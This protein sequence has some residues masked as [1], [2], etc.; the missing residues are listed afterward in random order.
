MSLTRHDRISST[1]KPW[2]SYYLDGRHVPG[3]TT[4]LDKTF[5]KPGLVDWAAAKVADAAFD[6]YDTTGDLRDLFATADELAAVPEQYKR[7]AAAR[8]TRVH[9][10]AERF[11]RGGTGGIGAPDI[12][13]YMRAFLDW[14]NETSPV[15]V[16]IEQPLANRTWQYA[17][18]VDLI[19]DIGGVRTLLDIKTGRSLYVET[20]LQLHG[21]RDCEVYVDAGGS[22]AAV[23]DLGIAAVSVLHLQDHGGW[24]VYDITT[25][26]EVTEVMHA[27]VWLY[28]TLKGVTRTDWVGV[29]VLSGFAAEVD[30]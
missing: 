10:A 30:A 13:G 21:Y 27:L 6:A 2:H 1:G 17:G 12:A 25:G 22:E 18:T 20:A 8:G 23:A 16:L 29:P 19:A 9:R 3:V 24:H 15:P 28:H 5:A 4:I 7:T 14:H 11:L 26:P